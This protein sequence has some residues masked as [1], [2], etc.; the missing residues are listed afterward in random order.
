MPKVK[1]LTIKQKMFLK[2]YFK[3]GNATEAAR[4][5]YDCKSDGTAANIGSENLIKLQIPVR[6]LMEKHGLSLGTLIVKLGEGLEAK[7]LHGTGDNFV[8]IEDY[9]VRHKYL[10]TAAKWLGVA[11]EGPDTLIQVNVQPILGGKSVSANISNKED[12]KTQ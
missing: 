10:E 1:D 2:E 11:K 6:A 7:K 9:A 8:E 5:S 12:T 4:K 3:T